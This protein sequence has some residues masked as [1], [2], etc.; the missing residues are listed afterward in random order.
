MGR[1][2]GCKK[3][4]QTDAGKRV[5]EHAVQIKISEVWKMKNGKMQVVIFQGDPRTIDLTY[6]DMVER[7]KQNLDQIAEIGEYRIVDITD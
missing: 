2:I 6:Q 3:Q 7:W 4:F 1:K 5:R